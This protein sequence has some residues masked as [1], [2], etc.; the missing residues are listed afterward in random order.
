M[1]NRSPWPRTRAAQPLLALFFAAAL[2]ALAAAPAQAQATRFDVTG[3]VT[4]TTDAPLSGATVVVMQPADSALVSFGTTRAD[5]SFRIGRVP[6]GRYLLQVT[7]VGFAPHT[8]ALAVEG[9]AV[10]V[11]RIR[12]SEAV[13]GLGELVISAE[14]I[15]VVVKRDTLEYNAA[16]F[17]VRPN[18]NVEELL[19]RLPGIEVERDGSIKAQGETVRKVLVD[20]KE[21]FGNDP[22]VATK[23]LPADAVDKVQVYDK[24]SDAAE[25]TGVDDGNAEKTINL[26][27]KEDRKQGYFGNVSGGLGQAMHYEA[28][29]NVNRFSPTTQ[30]SLI[31][32]LN[33]VNQQGFSINDYI[34]FMGGIQN[35]M[36]GGGR[37]SLGSVPLG[38]DAAAGFST[39]L[40]GGLNFNHDFGAKTSLRTSYLAYYLDNEQ[41][42]SVQQRQV[43]GAAQAA[44]TQQLVDQ[45]SRNLNHRLNL[46][47]K[48]TLGEGH[49]VQLRANL[50]ASDS[51]LDNG[52]Y[53]ETFGTSGA[54]EN[55]SRTDYASASDAL[56][57]D[58]TLTYRK[59]F[60]PGRSLTAE[61]RAG[62]NDN[63]L[64]A[65]LAA[66]NQF[67][68]AGNVL[69]SEELAQLQQQRANTFTNAQKLTYTEPL[70]K[71]QLLQFEAEHRQVREDQTRTVYDRGHQ[72]GGQ[73][74]RNDALSSAFD[75]AY[76]YLVGGLDFRRAVEPLTLSL[77]LR[78]QQ[79]H[80]QG[81]LGSTPDAVDRRF[82]HLLPSALLNYAFAQSKNVEL[83]YDASTR[84]PSVRDLQPFVDNSDPLNVY[85]GNPELR[86]EYAHN[87]M[88]RYF[89]FD[90]FS[91]V[92]L[93]AFVRAG[94]T[95]DKITRVRT[96]D[97]QLRQT[98][99]VTNADGDWSLTGNVSFGTPVRPLG[100]KVNLSA[101]S[102][103]NRGL[104]FIN[105]AENTA[106]IFRNTLDLRLENRNKA[107]LDASVGARYT[108]ND[109]RYSLNEALSQ[110]YVNRTFYTELTYTLAEVW[111]LTTSLDYNLYAREVF[112]QGQRVP[113]WHAELSRSVMN[114]RAEVKLMARDLLNQ[115]EGVDFSNTS[116]YVQEERVRSLGRYVMLK[117]VYNLA[118]AGRPSGPAI[119]ATR[120]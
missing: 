99:T 3:V 93:F 112:G 4:D 38:T 75:R 108:F 14:H 79:S 83:R 81:T 21:F 16:A 43:A 114:N 39:T 115:N 74:V 117:F 87:V 6:S 86:P 22:K 52:S 120:L 19:K 33:D 49:D 92:N 37:L 88:A 82:V 55:T 111:R 32:N 91:F 50:Q 29:A 116:T 119:R 2:A 53:R 61:V 18:A 107:T 104:D 84:E 103:F 20:G 110:H 89:F 44:L 109:V 65:D 25:F 106:R 58:A 66:L 8:Q 64:T 13:S 23:N 96:I 98:L 9:A 100:V 69:T 67:Y 70:G 63:D 59:R 12:L 7:F 42:R 77:G 68:R 95:F 60:A 76:R 11:G 26:A 56:N 10:D 24:R 5:G 45:T 113:L 62:L 30:L 17:S 80:L 48:H 46:N 78:V 101:Q 71:R 57:G 31:A 35:L 47:L 41:D 85:V 28:R 72:P 40:S 1:P 54:L 15:P 94:Y 36:S 105:G 27:L 34:S 51:D 90:Q 73:P 118:G 97:E 102:A